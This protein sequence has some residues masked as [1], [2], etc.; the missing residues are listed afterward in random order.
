MND[1]AKHFETSY[2]PNKSVISDEE[3]MR[4]ALEYGISPSAIKDLKT[5]DPGELT[6]RVTRM[7]AA[8]EWAHANLRDTLAKLD[9]PDFTANDMVKVA[10]QTAE[11]H[12]LFSKFKQ[13]SSELGRA[14][15]ALQAFHEFTNGNLSELMEN[16]R[17]G[18]N[19]GLAAMLD[20]TN[21]ESLKF[22][23][24]LK[25]A[26]GDGGGNGGPADNPKAANALLQGVNKPYWWQYL[27]AFHMNAM[28]SGLSTHVK[29]PIDMGTGIAREAMEKA[30]AM[31]I[32]QL[33]KMFVQM[34]G[35]T[36]QVG[37]GPEEMAAHV[38]G[39]ARSITDLEVYKAMGRALKTGN[40]EFVGPNGEAHASNFANQYGVLSTPRVPV[41]SIPTDLIAAQD[42]FFRS[43]QMNANLRG[44]GMRQA[45][46]ELGPTASRSQVVTMGESL[47][48]NP[49]L[50]MLKEAHDL[51]DRTLLLNGNKLN[52][53]I[54]KAKAVK[55][56]MN[57]WQQGGTFLAQNLAPFIRVESNNLINRVIQ[58]SPLGLLDPYTIK[59]L[60]AGGA[61]QDIAVAK[62]LY[63]TA[64]LG[65]YW[66]AADQGKKLLTGNG[67]D[68]AN[69]Y[70]EKVAGGFEPRAVNENG[71]YNVS[72]SLAMSVNPLDL[73]NA[74]ATMVKAAREAVD[75]A[76]PKN[77]G[78][79]IKMAFGS[80][81]HDLANLSWLNN[82]APPLELTSERGA[83][84]QQ[85]VG[86]FLGDQAKTW[87]PNAL[88]QATRLMDGQQRDTEVPNSIGGTMMND[89]K[90]SIPGLVNQVPVKY[91]VYGDPIPNGQSLTGVHTAIPGLQGNGREQVTDPTKVELQ[92]LGDLM[93]KSYKETPFAQ[94]AGMTPTLITPVQKT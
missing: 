84:A 26:I 57:G 44:L 61:R 40:G 22:A 49:T 74:T 52:S 20:P 23:R 89:I 36:P 86:Q 41:M 92:R 27:T 90:S 2:L 58:R 64:L 13:E 24:A 5:R 19:D 76:D 14:M 45:R 37:V 71:R 78:T 50:Q 7:G 47:A 83:T 8:A 3:T 56:G 94:R 10:Q 73:H 51:T 30:I 25:A 43:V 62:M 70:K 60:K 59:E 17:A 87:I 4:S 81:T 9:T 67:P 39:L 85:K 32:G 42:T 91:S 29:A 11:F 53:M 48:M 1:L 21:P 54:D 65:F 6:A 34:T 18:G 77:A 16:L 63:G 15:R 28:L 72:N 38:Y 33:R 75:N 68:D 69:K 46:T 35:R 82:A 31:P 55:P 66:A 80:I 12:G 93:E 79:M 88:G